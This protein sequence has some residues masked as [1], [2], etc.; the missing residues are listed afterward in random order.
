[1]DTHVYV[2]LLAWGKGGTKSFPSHPVTVTTLGQFLLLVS[3]TRALSPST[4]PPAGW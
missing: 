1:M 3:H 4:V 2:C